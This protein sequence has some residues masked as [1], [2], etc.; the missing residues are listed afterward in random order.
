MEDKSLE[1]DFPEPGENRAELVT[2]ARRRAVSSDVKGDV[3][4]DIP[5]TPSSR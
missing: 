3:D 4:D 5:A 2:L 1:N